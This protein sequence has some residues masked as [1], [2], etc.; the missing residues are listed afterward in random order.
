MLTP[1]FG[2]PTFSTLEST[3][4]H[5]TR[6]GW[7][8]L[9]SFTMQALGLSLLAAISLIWVER[10]PQVRWLDASAPAALTAPAA[11][12]AGAHHNGGAA[13][14]P[15]RGQIVTPRRVPRETPRIN[16]AGWEPT[17]A[18]DAPTINLGPDS[19]PGVGVAHGLGEGLPIV[20]PAR[21]VPVKPLIVSH[22]AEGNLIYRVQPIYPPIARQAH[23]QGTVELRAIVSKAG[24]DRKS[25]RDRRAPDVGQVGDGRGSAMALPPVSAEQRADRSRDGD[26]REL[27]AIGS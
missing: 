4:D 20:I 16:I 27:R 22:W 10:P 11:E 19:G 8:T 17:V 6:R 25:R 23:I 14:N 9:A 18:A 5:S 2:T 24:D 7:S 21:P 12:P 26:Y 1:T 13:N 15:T 3:W